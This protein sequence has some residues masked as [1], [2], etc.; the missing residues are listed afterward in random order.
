MCP[1]AGYR[2]IVVDLLPHSLVAARALCLSPLG[3]SQNSN[4]VVPSMLAF[5][6][7]KIDIR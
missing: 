5:N 2:Y 7:G 4:V 3:S 6:E 1:D